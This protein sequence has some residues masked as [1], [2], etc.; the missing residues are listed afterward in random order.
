[1]SRGSRILSANSSFLPEADLSVYHMCS[2]KY[3]NHF[4]GRQ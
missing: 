3:Y 1:M 4:L 2:A